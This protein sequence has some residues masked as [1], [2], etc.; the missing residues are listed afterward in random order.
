MS[1]FDPIPDIERLGYTPREAG[2]LA[3]V[4]SHSGFF[5][6]RHFNR[7]L[8][9]ED[10]GLA[11]SFLTKAL[12]K[13][14]VQLLPVEQRRF[15][16]HLCSRLPYRLCGIAESQDRRIKS[17]QTIKTMLLSL[18]YVLDHPHQ[19]FF[20]R[21]PQK[22]EYFRNTL[23]IPI[24]KLPSLDLITPTAGKHRCYFP[25]RFPVSIL[26][27][28]E[29]QPRRISFCFV[30]DGIE[31]LG[32]LSR[33]LLR[34]E[35]LLRSLPSSEIVYVAETE[36][37]FLDAGC[38]LSRAFPKLDATTVGARECPRGVCHFL[39]YLEAREIFEEGLT[40]PTFEQSRILAEGRSIYRTAAHDQLFVAWMKDDITD[41]E[42]VARYSE[43]RINISIRGYV[44]HAAFPQNG[45]KYRGME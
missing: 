40:S 3:L 26:S 39:S 13:K 35:Q 22:L 20:R 28:T 11:H 32:P 45:P 27:E 34:H 44:I 42:I 12:K 23:Q 7:Y 10:G 29:T 19:H 5:L 2:F 4:A 36:R 18:D 30:D 25:D 15:V 16:F 6:R 21:K 43:K 9:K 1:T 8:H 41:E 31:T 38:M 24:D 17:D 33:F 14:H 37:H